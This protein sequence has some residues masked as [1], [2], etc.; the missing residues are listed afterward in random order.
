MTLGEAFMSWRVERVS[1]EQ[2]ETQPILNHQEPFPADHDRWQELKRTM[3]TG[4][5]LWTFRSPEQEW[6][7]HMGWQGLVLVR[8]GRLIDE[9][10]TAQN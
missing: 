9:L 4:D 2:V 3:Q 7:R 10:V 6:D 5:E 8:D 1:V